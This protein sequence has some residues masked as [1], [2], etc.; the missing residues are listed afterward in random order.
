[1]PEKLPGYGDFYCYAITAGPGIECTPEIFCARSRTDAQIERER[2]RKM[3][4]TDIAANLPAI[5]AG[6]LPL[7][8][9]DWEA[10]RVMQLRYEMQRQQATA[11]EVWSRLPEVVRAA[12]LENQ[13]TEQET[14]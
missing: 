5:L 1:M 2:S 11:A 12:I 8:L 13:S 14:K 7:T 9:S 3:I 10:K 4:L 6:P